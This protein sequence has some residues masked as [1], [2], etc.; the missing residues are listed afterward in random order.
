MIVRDALSPENGVCL[1]ASIVGVI[2][3]F[4]AA[5]NPF[6]VDDVQCKGF[7]PLDDVLA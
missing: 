3:L 5:I 7:I 1:I 4:D 2:C 6:L